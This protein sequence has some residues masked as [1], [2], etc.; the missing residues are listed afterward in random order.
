MNEDRLG[1]KAA[2]TFNPT[3]LILQP[4]KIT[5]LRKIT[6]PKPWAQVFNSIKKQNK[7]KH[8][9]TH[10]KQKNKNLRPW[11]SVARSGKDS[12]LGGGGGG[13]RTRLAS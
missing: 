11:F 7:T 9:Y 4:N 2:N 8:T 13:C 12:F 3:L 1:L 6:R 5:L 10:T